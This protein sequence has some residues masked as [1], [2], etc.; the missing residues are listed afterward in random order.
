MMIRRERAIAVELIKHS[1]RVLIQ[2][3]VIIV[4]ILQ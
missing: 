1:P 4:A 2:E 3:L